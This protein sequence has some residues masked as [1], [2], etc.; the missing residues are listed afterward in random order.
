MESDGAVEKVGT[1]LRWGT[2]GDRWDRWDPWCPASAVVVRR[3]KVLPERLPEHCAAT[4]QYVDPGHRAVTGYRPAP[5][6]AS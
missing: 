4:V 1:V 5:G 6:Y 2:V 3:A